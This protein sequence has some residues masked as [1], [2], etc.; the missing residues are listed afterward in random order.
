MTSIRYFDAAAEAAGTN[1]EHIGLDE[2]GAQEISVDQ[3]DTT[4]GELIDHLAAKHSGL[5]KILDDATFL[6]NRRPGDCNT[7]LP[8]GA[9]V[10]VHP[11]RADG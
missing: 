1:F 4:L 8:A 9:V 5:A 11:R 3:H 6:V 7:P 2:I 10:D